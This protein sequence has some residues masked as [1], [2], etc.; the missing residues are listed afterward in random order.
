MKKRG[1]IFVFC[2]LLASGIVL[3]ACIKENNGKTIALIGTEYYITEQ[4]SFLDSILSVIQ[5]SVRPKFYNSFGTIPRG[6][7]P[8][9]LDF[10]PLD[11]TFFY[12]DSI[13]KSSYVVAPRHLDTSN[14]PGLVLNVDLNNA[15]MRFYGQHNGVVGILFSDGERTVTDTAFVCGNES[16]FA[17]YF[18]EDMAYVIED[19]FGAH[20][21][22]MKR[23]VIMK[24]QVA[25]AGLADFRYATI[26][27]GKDDLDH[28]LPDIGSYYIYKDGN[29][30]ADRC[31]W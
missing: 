5:D 12:Q 23:G 8:P 29:M 28:V 31:N 10:D 21:V 1:N 2:I 16:E 25:D 9:Q 6:F 4:Q 14:V 3:S 22:K 13:K 24:G 18:I 30:M 15:Y 7:V 27:L 17:V 19:S 20:N 11:S 26:L